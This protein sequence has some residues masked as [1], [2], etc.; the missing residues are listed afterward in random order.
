MKLL[1]HQKCITWCIC[2]SKYWCEFWWISYSL[3]MYIYIYIVFRFSPLRHNWWMK[4]DTARRT[5]VHN[6]ETCLRTDS[7][8]PCAL[9]VTSLAHYPEMHFCAQGCAPLGHFKSLGTW[10]H[11]RCTS[12]FAWSANYQRMCTTWVLKCARTWKC[13][14]GAQPC[15]QWCFSA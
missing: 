11:K 13:A 15:P 8:K 1:W 5:G 7:Y 10:A 14:S 6:L 4:F 2:Q 12:L 3:H 9:T